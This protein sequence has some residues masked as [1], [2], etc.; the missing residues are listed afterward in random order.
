[1]LSMPIAYARMSKNT[2]LSALAYG[3]VY[4]FRGTPLLAQTFLI[5]YGVGS[6]RPQLEA[7]GLWCVLPRSLVLR[8]P[9]LHAEHRGLS[10]RNPARRD[11]KRSA[12]ASGKAPLRSACTSCQTLRKVILPQALIVA[13]RPY[14]NEIILMI[15]GSAVVA[16]ITVFDLMGETRLAYS[17]Q[18]RLPDLYLGGA[19]LSRHRRDAAPRDRMDRAAHYHSPASLTPTCSSFAIRKPD[20]RTERIHENGIG[21]VHRAWRDGLSDGRAPE[22]EGRP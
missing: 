11:R 3:Y 1:M 18:L 8:D 20:H 9:G 7:V 21:C 10:G 4:F 2:I 14:G 17:P 15:K 12:G 13:L 22:E 19:H 5:Y 16:L 6:F